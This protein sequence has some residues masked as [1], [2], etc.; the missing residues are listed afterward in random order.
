MEQSRDAR[1]HLASLR[2]LVRADR[3]VILSAGYDRHDR[4]Y[5]GLRKLDDGEIGP[6]EDVSVGNL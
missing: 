3:R 4:L 5:Y 2:P 6:D 1:V